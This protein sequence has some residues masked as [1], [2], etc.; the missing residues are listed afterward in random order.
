MTKAPENMTKRSEEF[1]KYCDNAFKTL[2]NEVSRAKHLLEH[3]WG[4]NIMESRQVVGNILPRT[5]E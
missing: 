3:H 4:Q 2:S 5:I 1:E